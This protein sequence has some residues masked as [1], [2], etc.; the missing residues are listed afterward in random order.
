MR[1]VVSILYLLTYC[2]VINFAQGHGLK[3]FDLNHGLAGNIVY[4]IEQDTLDY[5]WFGTNNGLSRYDGLNFQNYNDPILQNADIILLAEMMGT[6]YFLNINRQLFCIQ[7]NRIV[8]ADPEVFNGNIYAFI[9]HPS[10]HCIWYYNQDNL[11]QY[12]LTTKESIC[13]TNIQNITG[14]SAHSFCLDQEQNL[15]ILAKGGIYKY[16]DRTLGLQKVIPVEA[17]P[18]NHSFNKI[19]FHHQEGIFIL[20]T[21][22]TSF[23][24]LPLS[25]NYEKRPN[26]FQCSA[27]LVAMRR[28]ATGG[29]LIKRKFIDSTKKLAT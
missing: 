22:M 15:W 1:K 29:F 17:F 14:T 8:P 16:Q 2:C 24:K 9:H 18:P 10:D 12:D 27:T 4:D 20:L 25:I 11:F 7:N 26:L 13:H 23:I 19:T 6:M 21:A 28:Q 3:Q 5:L